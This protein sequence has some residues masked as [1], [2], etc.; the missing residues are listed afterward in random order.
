M[1][2]FS[3]WADVKVVSFMSAYVC[4]S[5]ESAYT[6]FSVGSAYVCDE[7][8]SAYVCFSSWLPRRIYGWRSRSRDHFSKVV[9]TAFGNAAA[10]ETT[11]RKYF[12]LRWE[13]QPPEKTLFESGFSCVGRRSRPRNMFRKWFFLRWDWQAADPEISSEI[14]S[15]GVLGPTPLGSGGGDSELKIGKQ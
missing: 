7:V 14:L 11:S 2:R 8:V 15:D 1:D 6:C 13:A 4:F 5:V 3:V 9:L 12:F 10:R